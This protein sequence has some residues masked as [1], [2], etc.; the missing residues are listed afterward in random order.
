MTMS[1][2]LCNLSVRSQWYLVC[3][4]ARFVAPYSEYSLHLAKSFRRRRQDDLLQREI[5][6]VASKTWHHHVRLICAVTAVLNLYRAAS[7]SGVY[8]FPKI[9]QTLAE[10]PKGF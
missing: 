1:V 10:N 3:H 7:C 9:R 6:I 8:E 2:V 5:R 4:V